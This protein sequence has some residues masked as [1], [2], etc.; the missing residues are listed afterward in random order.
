MRLVPA[1]TTT[2]LGGLLASCSSSVDQAQSDYTFL[3]EH[4]GTPRELCA[5]ASKVEKVTADAHDTNGYKYAQIF[6]ASECSSV[7]T[8]PQYAD[9]PGGIPKA[10]DG[11]IAN[12]LAALNSSTAE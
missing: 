11:E 8:F 5:A 2:V 1:I 9:T 4:N 12:Q 6:R 7:E 10:S 3:K